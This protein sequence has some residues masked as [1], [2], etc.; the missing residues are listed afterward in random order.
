MSRARR[1]APLRGWRGDGPLVWL[2]RLAAL[3]AVLLAGRWMVRGLLVEGAP[4][5]AVCSRHGLDRPAP[6]HLGTLQARLVRGTDGALALIGDDLPR[7]PADDPRAQLVQLALGSAVDADALMSHGLSGGAAAGL[8]GTALGVG[9]TT[10]DPPD[11]VAGQAGA[12]RGRCLRITATLQLTG[13]TPDGRR[14]AL[15]PTRVRQRLGRW[16]ARGGP[17]MTPRWAMASPVVIG[18]FGDQMPPLARFLGGLPPRGAVGPASFLAQRPRGRLHVRPRAVAA[19]RGARGRVSV[20]DRGPDAAPEPDPESGEGPWSSDDLAVEAR[21]SDLMSR[22]IEDDDGDALVE[23]IDLLDARLERA[24]P[25]VLDEL[26][27]LVPLRL[28]A[29]WFSSLLSEDELDQKTSVHPLAAALEYMRAR[30]RGLISALSAQPLPWEDGYR[31]SLPAEWLGRLEIED[32]EPVV[33]F[34][35]LVTLH[36]LPQ[37]TRQVLRDLQ[38]TGLEPAACATRRGLTEAQVGQ[39]LR[40]GRLASL[41]AI[42]RYLRG[43]GS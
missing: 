9:F 39:C 23:L 26:G 11:A 14:A 31:A 20:T 7:P 37:T 1:L 25:H 35:N 36:R 28:G 42:D 2:A 19:P 18:W 12:C 40:E 15:V 29:E 41:Q 8:T 4:P 33:T 22:L 6:E 13:E 24:E 34:V 16:S 5:C 10:D 32:P 30:G 21:A 27:S 17:Q 38:V 43:E 3:A